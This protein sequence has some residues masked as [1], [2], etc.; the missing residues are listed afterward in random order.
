MDISYLKK[1]IQELKECAI[2]NFD[3]NFNKYI[4]T[5]LRD[6]YADDPGYY[7]IEDLNYYLYWID[8]AVQLKE[9]IIFLLNKISYD[10]EEYKLLMECIQIKRVIDHNII[11]YKIST[12][13]LD[14]SQRIS[15]S[16]D[17]GY[18]IEEMYPTKWEPFSITDKIKEKEEAI[19]MI[20]DFLRNKWKAV[21]V[22]FDTFKIHFQ[23]GKTGTGLINWN[24]QLQYL[25]FLYKQ[26]FNGSIIT[27]NCKTDKDKC[28]L[29]SSHFK[30]K[31]EPLKID[32]L[33]STWSNPIDYDDYKAENFI[34]EFKNKFDIN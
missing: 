27:N 2:E 26:L 14:N 10:D 30:L 11:K 12:N 29:V 16:E 18:D 33:K 4:E 7:V 23:E 6:G 34:K 19:R 5:E 15:I 24:Q 13:N 1:T 32:S 25:A 17:I 8:L 28:R 9:P 21:E 20:Y 22:D 3:E 31:G